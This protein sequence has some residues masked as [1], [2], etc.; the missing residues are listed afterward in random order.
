MTDFSFLW[1]EDVQEDEYVAG[2][3]ALIDSGDAWRLEGSVGRSAN[4]LIDRRLCSLGP[5]RH[6]DCYGNRIP[7]KFDIE[8]GYPGSPLER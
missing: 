2:M 5:K 8:P 4:D 3:Q 7:S 1:R 6:T